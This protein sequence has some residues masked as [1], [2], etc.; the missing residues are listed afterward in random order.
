MIRL[1]RIIIKGFKDPEREVDFEFS[2]ENITVVYGE[3]GCGKTTFL[4]IL[5]AVFNRNENI[6]KEEKVQ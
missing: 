6:L 2:T 4:R 3:N 1:H 5:H